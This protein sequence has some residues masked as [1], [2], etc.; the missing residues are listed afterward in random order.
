[1]KTLLTFS[2]ILFSCCAFSQSLHDETQFKLLQSGKVKV[3]IRRNNQLKAVQHINS[4]KKTITEYSL[5]PLEKNTKLPRYDSTFAFSYFSIH[6]FN[7]SGKMDSAFSIS[8]ERRT[9]GTSP[10][11]ETF[12]DTNVY[13]YDYIRSRGQS[14]WIKNGKRTINQTDL[15]TFNPKKQLVK[16][17]QGGHIPTVYT[18]NAKG[19]LEKEVIANK[20]T[21]KYEYNAKGLLIKKYSPKVVTTYEY[22]EDSSL[23]K[24]ETIKKADTEVWT[25][26]YE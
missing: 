5:V 16:F 6:C 13:V 18:Y 11:M 24:R 8:Y 14:I 12:I 2:S 15:F 10:I 26:L 23:L 3:E 4:V 22:Y 19:Q 20:V 7:A 25:Y 17:M 21:Y 1:M 9:S